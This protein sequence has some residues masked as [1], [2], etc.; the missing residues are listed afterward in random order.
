MALHK[1]VQNIHSKCINGSSTDFEV[2][3]RVKESLD[4]FLRRYI[5]KLN[6]VIPNECSI[7]YKQKTLLFIYW[8]WLAF[9]IVFIL[10]YVS[11]K[12]IQLY[13]SI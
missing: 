5:Y 13:F 8:E 7:G 1:Y 4:T 10:K 3:L 12:V 2:Y 11:E 9:A 6:Q